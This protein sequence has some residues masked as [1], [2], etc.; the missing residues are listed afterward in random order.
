MFIAVTFI[1]AGALLV[2]RSF[3]HPDTWARVFHLTAIGAVLLALAGFV[4]ESVQYGRVPV[5]W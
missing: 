1:L 4:W 2:A 3:V 5:T